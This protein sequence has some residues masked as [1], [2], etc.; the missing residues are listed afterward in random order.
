MTGQQSYP[1]FTMV[2]SL[3]AKTKLDSSDIA[4][5]FDWMVRIH[6]LPLGS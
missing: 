6:H 3:S 4:S 1:V 2:K 5:L